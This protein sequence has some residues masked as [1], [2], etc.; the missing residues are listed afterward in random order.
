MKE[1]FEDI[2]G[3]DI[4]PYLPLCLGWPTMFCVDQP[5]DGTVT[6]DSDAG[7][8]LKAKVMDDIRDVL[9]Q[10]TMENF[11]IPLK[12]WLN[13]EYNIKLR[14]QISYGKYL[15]ISRPN[16]AVDYPETES[17]NQRD[18][19]DMYRVHAGA[20]HLLNQVL[21]SETG[22]HGGMNYGYSLQEHLQQAYTE[23]AGGVNRVIWHGYSS[24]WTQAA[25]ANWP[26]FIGGM[27]NINGRWNFRNP[28]HKDYGEYNDHLGRV[29]TVLRA[30][31]PQVD[32]AI[33]YLDYA[34][35]LPYGTA[36]PDEDMGDLRQQKHEGWQW[37]DLTLQDA[38][39]TYDY[40]A[41][42][43]LDDGYAPYDKVKGLLAAD[44]PAYQALLVYQE[45]IPLASAQKV[46][47]MAKD[48]LKVILV[49]GAMTRTAWNDGKET[50]L[51]SVRQ[52]LLGFDNVTEVKDQKSAYAA[53]KQLDVAP[54]AGYS[55]LDKE[56]LSVTR[57]DND[58]TYLFLYNYYNVMKGWNDYPNFTASTQFNDVSNFSKA[59]SWD[60]EIDVNS[61]EVA[62][63]LKPYLLDTWTGEVSEVAKYSHKSGKTIVPIE[64]PDGDVR[65]YIFKETAASELRVTSTD[66][67]EVFLNDGTF[68]VRSVESGDYSV[69]LS[70]GK[71]YTGVTDVPASKSLTGWD[72]NVESW[73]KGALMEPRVENTQ[74]GNTTTEYAFTT[75]KDNISFNL[76]YLKTWNN[77]PKVGRNVSGVGTY[78]TVFNWDK[79]KASGAYLDMGPL[80]ESA[81]VFVNENKTENLNLMDAVV[82]I[83]GSML[84]DGANS[85]KIVVTGPLANQLLAQNWNG[86][87]L[88]EGAWSN[89]YGSFLLGNYPGNYFADHV[90]TYFDSGLPQ[91]I[92]KPYVDSIVYAPAAPT[93]PEEPTPP[94]EP[95]PPNPPASQVSVNMLQVS[96]ANIADKVYTGKKIQPAL[97]VSYN[98][99]ALAAGTDYDV[100]YGANTSIGRGTVSITGKGAYTGTKAVSFKIIPKKNSVKKVTVGKKSAKVYLN[101][102]SSAQK[103]TGYQVQYRQKGTSKWKSKTVSAKNASVTIK[104]LKKGKQY[105]FRVRPFKTVAGAKYFASW[106]AVKTGKKIK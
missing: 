102:V 82:D 31:V 87:A 40:F 13:D 97:S 61:V 17:R 51:A 53:L 46:L 85:L 69:K 20:T 75:K 89:G 22:A 54:R 65:V 39:Y 27:G 16:I 67:Q 66:A 25:S 106:S 44:G 103:V 73:S 45:Q 52:E 84:K 50:E 5:K 72:V 93:L 98:G 78:K 91:A 41:P 32:L 95:T 74:F 43:Y 1:K 55:K 3:Y 34:Y 57:K 56:L 29:Q 21:S 64:I 38:G 4:M 33:L 81:T 11:M 9:T 36:T 68:T 19:T 7:K 63:Y 42:Q 104:K 49:K 79:T 96:V 80:V 71:T 58:A 99:K 83:P 77:L 37:E 30:G 15:E 86:G 90:Y 94:A 76:K 28:S 10:F 8:T 23:Y 26:E 14:A 12:Q 60:E 70:N 18:Q 59:A 6:F 2:K 47:D 105:Q 24:V 100:V 88:S 92:L 48:G 101:K 35:Q 62:G